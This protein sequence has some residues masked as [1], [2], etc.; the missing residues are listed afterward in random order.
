MLL[1]GQKSPEWTECYE[2]FLL[3]SCRCRDDCCYGVDT[4]LQSWTFSSQTDGG[5]K[6]V[7]CSQLKSHGWLCEGL[8]S[9]YCSSTRFC[10]ALW[11]RKKGRFEVAFPG[12][13]NKI[14]KPLLMEPGASGSWRPVHLS[15][16]WALAQVIAASLLTVLSDKHIYSLASF[17]TD[18]FSLDSKMFV[19]KPSWFSHIRVNKEVFFKCFKCVDFF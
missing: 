7:Y 9:H 2:W 10:D 11:R 5:D 13:E 1:R 19:L 14:P 16:S 18:N 17:S 15:A 3:P 4:R 12:L 6:R 8:C